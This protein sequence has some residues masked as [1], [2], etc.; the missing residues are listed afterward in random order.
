MSIIHGRNLK[1]YSGYGAIIGAAK[2]CSIHTQGDVIEAAGASS[3]TAR[4][5]TPGRTSWTIEVNHLVTSDEP[6]GKLLA[7]NSIVSISVMNG[8][9]QILSGTAIITEA[10]IVAT[11]GSLANGSIRL[12][13]TGPLNQ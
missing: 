11:K 5:F 10:T 8:N 9:S 12:Q 7:T 3:G 4:T 1:I 6:T 2:S 13:G